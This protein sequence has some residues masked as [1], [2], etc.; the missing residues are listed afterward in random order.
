MANYR[1][2]YHVNAT[3]FFTVNQ[4]ERR[5]DALLVNKI[6]SLRTAF[7]Y[8]KQRKPFQ[9][10]AIVILPDHLH[11][12]WTLPQNDADFSI[13]WNMLKGHFSRSLAKPNPFL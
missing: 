4:A 6:E 2:F 13:R 8:V 1:R 12:I 5:D 7:S 9:I 10:D 3:W 11:T